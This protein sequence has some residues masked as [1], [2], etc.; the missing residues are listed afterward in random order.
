MASFPATTEPESD[1]TDSDSEDGGLLRR[2]AERAEQVAN[3]LSPLTSVL[4]AV[5]QFYTVKK[6][7][8]AA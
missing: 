3:L 7:V 5:V 8:G 6:L 1:S 4:T 2:L